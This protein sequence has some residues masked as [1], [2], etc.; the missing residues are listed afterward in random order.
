MTELYLLAI[1]AAALLLQLNLYMYAKR[2]LKRQG[3]KDGRD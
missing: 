3:G 2:A 1:V